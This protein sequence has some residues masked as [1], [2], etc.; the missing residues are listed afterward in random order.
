MSVS[1]NC[2]EII[3]RLIDYRHRELERAEC[4]AIAAHLGA[5]PGCALEYC[6]LDADLSGIARALEVEP[7]VEVRAALRKKVARELA[8]SPWSRLTAAISKPIPIYQAALV[9]AVVAVLWLLFSVARPA[10][11]STVV[12]DRYDASTIVRIDRDLL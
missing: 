2:G 4:E 5:C 3:D 1:M 10:P 11:S 12:L 7:R 8:R 9:A 6:R